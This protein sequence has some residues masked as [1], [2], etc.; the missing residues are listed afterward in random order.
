DGS[1]KQLSGQEKR[2]L[3][4]SL[5]ANSSSRVEKPVPLQL[6]ERPQQLSDVH[7]QRERTPGV[8][9]PVGAQKQ[10]QVLCRQ[11]SQLLTEHRHRL[12]PPSKALGRK[13][14]PKS[15]RCQP[16]VQFNELRSLI[17]ER[18]L[19][20]RSAIRLAAVFGKLQS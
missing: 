12:Q 17:D 10:Q 7:H 14:K 16:V 2:Q 13:V 18:F 11:R 19:P 4:H 8:F 9:G 15:P 20:E 3:Q 5:A 1:V 6:R